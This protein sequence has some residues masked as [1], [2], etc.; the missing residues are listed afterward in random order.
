MADYYGHGGGAGGSTHSGGGNNA[1]QNRSNNNNNNAAGGGGADTGKI[2]V[3]G[4]SWQ[5]TEE[6]LRWHFEQY[7]TVLSTEIM[8]DRNT[9]DPRGFGFVVFSDPA[10]VDLVM[11]EANH[12][13]NHKIVDVKRAQARGIAPPSI[14]QSKPNAAGGGGGP[15]GPAVASSHNGQHE[16][17]ASAA[18]N[19]EISPEQ[20]QTKVFVGGI[21]PQIDR[22]QL[23]EIFE[24]FGPVTD[25]VV[26]M[27]QATQRSRC[28]GFVTFQHG[29]DGATKAV[30]AQPLQIYN[31][32]VEV[33]L[34]T[35]RAEQQGGRRP[36]AAAAAAAAGPRHL[37][38]RA[39]QTSASSSSGEF[40]GLAVAYGRNGWKAG[41]GSRAF[42]RS[43]WAVQGW[44]DGGKQFERSGFSFAM[45]DRGHDGQPAS[46]RSKH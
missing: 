21:P 17:V 37:G 40:A 24:Q 1:F 45:L 8:R 26:M 34:A 32:K 16:G 5:T 30:E 13:V 36:I 29:T 31:R 18:T 22:D 19:A 25:A 6:S 10:T 28:F 39:G 35:P 15:A 27:D 20:A 41:Y 2:F 44:E 4:L 11:Q 46:K 7:G 43:G 3:G 23:R 38:L 14:H 42:G 33:K 12:E 9:G